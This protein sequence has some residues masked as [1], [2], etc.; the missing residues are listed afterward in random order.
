MT[1]PPVVV[2]VPHASVVIPEDLRASFR[3]SPSELARELLA[4]TDLHTDEIFA[5]PD[6][7]ARSVVF[8]FS[9]LVVDP[10]RFADDAAEPMAAKG[11]GVFYTRTSDGRVLRIHGARSNGERARLWALYHAHHAAFA[12]AVSCALEDHG[13]CLVVDAHSFPSRPLPYE[14][15]PR[16][17]RPEI[18]IGTDPT[19]TPTLLRETAV[20]AFEG[21]GFTVAVDRPFTGA[22]VPRE[23]YGREPRVMSVM[24]EV[25]RALYMNENSGARLETFYYVRAKIRRAVRRIVR[26]TCLTTTRR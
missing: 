4:M 2:H 9:R 19:H 22:I 20:D 25:N 8:P 24:I 16:R 21:E 14:D 23:H 12:T 6:D 15:D 11:L 18:C 1:V 13:K 5:L 3:L 7:E 26:D 17:D 10:E